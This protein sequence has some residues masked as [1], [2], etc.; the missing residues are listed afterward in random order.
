MG[1]SGREM[2]VVV[3]FVVFYLR[4]SVYRPH[5]TS[6]SYT[7]RVS[8]LIGSLKVMRGISAASQSCLANSGSNSCTLTKSNGMNFEVPPGSCINM[9]A[10]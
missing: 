8:G 1:V 4:K 10:I 3:S 6:S 5:P 7:K 9:D 2:D